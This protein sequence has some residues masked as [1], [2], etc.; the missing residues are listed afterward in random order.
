MVVP[1]PIKTIH[2]YPSHT[3]TKNKNKSSL[4]ETRPFRAIAAAVGF[5][6]QKNVGSVA[7]PQTTS[8]TLRDLKSMETSARYNTGRRTQATKKRW[9]DLLGGVTAAAAAAAAAA[10]SSAGLGF[11]DSSAAAVP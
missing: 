6:Q 7:D 9:S 4:Y 8:Q 3:H 2:Y 1:V 5:Y 11:P 10:T